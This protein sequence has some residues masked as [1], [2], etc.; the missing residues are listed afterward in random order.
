MNKMLYYYFMLYYYTLQKINVVV[1]INTNVV[2]CINPPVY[3]PPPY[4]SPSK[5][6]FVCF[7]I[8]PVFF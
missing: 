4:I 3:K 1:V 5:N 8:T 2:P 7:R 6:P